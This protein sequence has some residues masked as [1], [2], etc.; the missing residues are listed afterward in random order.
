MSN[1]TKTG[2]VYNCL[3]IVLC[4]ITIIGANGWYAVGILITALLCCAFAALE[5]HYEE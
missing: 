2:I 1:L 3:W 4:V 5:Q